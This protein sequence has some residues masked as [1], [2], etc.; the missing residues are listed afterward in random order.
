MRSEASWGILRH[1]GTLG[2][3]K[4]KKI[5]RASG[6]RKMV[7]KQEKSWI[8]VHEFRSPRGPGTESHG[9]HLGVVGGPLKA[10][11]YPRRDR[12]CRLKALVG[13]PGRAKRAKGR[14]KWEGNEGLS[15]GILRHPGDTREVWDE[16]IRRVPESRKMAQ[17]LKK[18]WIKSTNLGARGP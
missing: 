3:S 6:S 15:H 7:Q 18:S 16:K 9:V 17:K 4:P 8:I 11:S 5:R 14:Q 12:W 2:R 10:H 13:L 1:P